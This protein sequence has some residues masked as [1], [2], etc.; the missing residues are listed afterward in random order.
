MDI[1]QRRSPQLSPEPL[2]ERDVER[3]KSVVK[4]HL[5]KVKRERTYIMQTRRDRNMTS[6]RELLDPV[7]TA[8]KKEEDSGS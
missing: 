8:K 2:A 3:Q 4:E 5:E 6:F 7:L 1:T